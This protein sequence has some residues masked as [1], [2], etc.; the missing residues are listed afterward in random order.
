MDSL[1]MWIVNGTYDCCF[2]NVDEYVMS[3]EHAIEYGILIFE[4]QFSCTLIYNKYNI[5]SN[6]LTWLY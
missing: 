2:M 1:D 4:C 6:I 3:F 5:Y